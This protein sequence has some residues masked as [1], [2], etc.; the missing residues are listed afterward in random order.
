MG[1]GGKLGC[2]I[3]EHWVVVAHKKQPRLWNPVPQTCHQ[4]EAVAQAYALLQG[5]LAGHLNSH[6]VCQR[7]AEGNA[8]LND[9]RPSFS[10]G[11]HQFEGRLNIRVPRRQ[12][13]HQPGPSLTLH[14]LKGFSNPAHSWAV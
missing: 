4:I 3:L 11:R 10:Q 9:I 6:S 8:Q 5:T 7:V 12:E 14:T 13:D 2:A 1:V